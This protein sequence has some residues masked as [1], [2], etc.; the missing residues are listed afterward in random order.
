[1]LASI[2][3]A[4]S[5][6]GWVDVAD[7]EQSLCWVDVAE[8]TWRTVSSDCAEWTWLSGRGGLWAVTVLSGRGWVDVADCE[9]SLCWEWTWRTASS[10][11]AESGRGGLWAV[12]VLSGRG[13]LWA[14]TVLRVDVADCEQ[15]LCWE[16]TWRTVSSDCAEWTWRTVSSD[17]AGLWAV[18]SWA[19]E[20]LKM[21]QRRSTLC[22]VVWWGCVTRL[23]VMYLALAGHYVT[24]TLLAAWFVLWTEC[25]ESVQSSWHQLSYYFHTRLQS[26]TSRLAVSSVK[27]LMTHCE[28]S[29]CLSV[30]LWWCLCCG[31]WR[32]CVLVEVC[33][34]SPSMCHA[35]LVM[36]L[37]GGTNTHLLQFLFDCSINV[38]P[39]KF[40][41]CCLLLTWYTVCC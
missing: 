1:M 2:H 14:V 39:G 24:H 25:C 35:H 41:T 34:T 6:R 38:T 33:S 37:P 19:D 10:H 21:K 7:C 28:L 20:K 36:L 23:L 22:A 16:W 5:G 9:Q 15:W 40:T 3:C 29:V 17:C 31:M 18:A 30:C 13:G 26:C 32:W 11:C 4:E 8:W 12:T 27:A